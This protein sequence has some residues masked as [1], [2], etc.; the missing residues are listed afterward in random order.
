M[1]ERIELGSLVK[2]SVTGFEGVVTG[3]SEYITGCAQILVQPPV[4]R[5]GEF[6]ESRWF[7]EPRCV[8]KQARVL[9]M[10]RGAL[11][12]ADRPAPRR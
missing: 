2:D 5:N 1:A 12:G 8:L 9:S 4:K 6:V 3:R 7:D 11:A 10:I